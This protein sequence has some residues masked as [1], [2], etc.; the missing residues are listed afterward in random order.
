MADGDTAIRHHASSSCWQAGLARKAKPRTGGRSTVALVSGSSRLSITPPIV[1]AADSS[2]TRTTNAY[3]FE[4]LS[5]KI[6]CLSHL[7]RIGTAAHRVSRH[8]SVND[9]HREQ[10]HTNH[11]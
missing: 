3:V 8:N 11:D 10:H 5:G 4:R 7:S 1:S 2:L 6:N 9:A